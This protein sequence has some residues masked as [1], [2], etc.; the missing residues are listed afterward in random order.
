MSSTKTVKPDKGSPIII[1]IQGC[2]NIILIFLSILH[3]QLNFQPE[4]LIYPACLSLLIL[5]IWSFWSWQKLTTNLFDPYTLFFLS[6]VL[7][8]GGHALLEVFH[9]NQR[10]ILGDKFPSK[11]L[12]ETL[13]IVILGLSSLH[14][15]AL[16]SVATGKESFSRDNSTKKVFDQTTQATY[17][18]GLGLIAI[19]FF[20]AL[21]V[22]KNAIV[23]V[24]EKGYGALYQDQETSFSA[25]PTLL[26]SFIIPGVFFLLAASKGRVG[27][28]MASAIITVIYS[29][30]Q[31]FLGARASAVMPLIAFA[32]LWNHLVRPIPKFFLLSAALLM[33]FIVFPFI[34]IARDTTGA[35]R[36]SLS[37]L[38]SAFSS[39]D[40]PA[41]VAITEMGN[42]MQTIA[43]TM[44]LVPSV[45]FFAMGV[46]YLC[47][48]LTV[49][50][51]FFGGLHPAMTLA[52]YDIPEF[53]MTW[54]IEPAFAARGGSFG[55]SFIAEA[56]LNFGWFGTPI[57]LGVIGFL[58]GRFTLWAVSSGEPVKMAMLATFLSYFL[59]YA[60]AQSDFIVRPLVW[61][62]LIPYLC[63][64]AL[65]SS[66]TK[67]LLR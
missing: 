18:V 33:V 3:E 39:I 58:F 60:R 30:T 61:Y 15:G 44:E 31:F 32:W 13:F 45:R 63:V 34:S 35:E 27:I 40:N 54:E 65:R 21:F 55:Y 64:C 24:L 23:T 41:I 29:G 57:T 16:L 66:G 47:S 67:K 9:L 49:I 46:T 11:I 59:F 56:Y 48:L 25:A 20:P 6:A 37:F 50:P 36:S 2:V 7:F 52:G 62:S 8:N 19:S 5:T 28:N 22:F 43:W 10:G 4:S 1:A 53:W 38:T 42:N 26:A 17:K 51:N 12:L 14:L